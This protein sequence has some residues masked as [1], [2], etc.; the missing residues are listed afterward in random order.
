MVGPYA[1]ATGEARR[2]REAAEKEAARAAKESELKAENDSRRDVMLQRLRAAE[3]RRREYLTAVRERAAH[4]AS[5]S[6]ETRFS[7]AG[8]DV[9]APPSPNKVGRCRLTYETHFESAWF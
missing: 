6:K 9:S 5:T 8:L 4:P 3:E 7:S 2:A 1:L